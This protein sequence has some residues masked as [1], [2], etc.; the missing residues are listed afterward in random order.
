MIYFAAV[1]LIFSVFLRALQEIGKWRLSWTYDYLAKALRYR[2]KINFD[3]YHIASNVHWITIYI[4][5]DLLSGGSFVEMGLNLIIV[6][7]IFGQ[8]FNVFYH[9][10]LIKPEFRDYKER[11][12]W[13]RCLLEWLTWKKSD[14]ETPDWW[15]DNPPTEILP[16]EPDDD[17]DD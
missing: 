3:P 4:L 13:V 16:W 7:F 15:P 14:E 9:F 6:Y 10:L 5:A 2:S 1:I 8:V 12:S 11:V 17:D